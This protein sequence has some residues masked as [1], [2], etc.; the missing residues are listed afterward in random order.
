MLTNQYLV[1]KNPVAQFTFLICEMG[2][3]VSLSLQRRR[4]RNEDQ[5]YSLLQGRH[6]LCPSAPSG[7]KKCFQLGK[8]GSRCTA[9]PIDDRA[10]SPVVLPVLSGIVGVASVPWIPVL[11]REHE[12]P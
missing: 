3:V 7:A 10:V 12:R 8:R 1:N 6:S 2:R 9:L 11:C 5:K 4:K